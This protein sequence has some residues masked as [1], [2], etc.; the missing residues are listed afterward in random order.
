VAAVLE[1]RRHA[2]YSVR[3]DTTRLSGGADLTWRALIIGLLGVLGLNL[4]TPVNDFALGNTYLTGNH[5]PVG[6]FFLLLILV[7]VVNLLLGWARR[8]WPL[9]RAE[10]MLVFTMMLVASTVPASGL[11]RYWFPLTASP[12]YLSQRSDF[13]WED[14]VLPAAP[15]GILLS[16]DPHSV[17]SR[18][19]FLG[20]PAGEPVVVPWHEWSRVILAWSP[21]ILC[22]YGATFFLCGILRRQWVDRERLLFPIARVPLELTEGVGEGGGLPPVFRSRA[23][24]VG[25]IVVITFGLIRVA[26]VLTGAE[27]GTL[28]TVP[29]RAFLQDTPLSRMNVADGEVYPLIIGIAFLVAAEVSL[30]MWLFFLLNCAENQLFYSLAVPI[31]G[32]PWGFLVWQQAGA[33]LA[34]TAAMLW[35]SRRHLLDVARNALGIGRRTDDSAEPVSFRFAAW[36]LLGCSAGMVAWYVHFGL[37]IG[38]A[39]ALL[40]LVFS[41]VLVHARLICQGGVILTG[42][43]WTP[44]TF[45]HSIMGGRAFSPEAVVVVQAQHAILTAD[46]REMLSPHAMNAMR[47]A[48]VFERHRRLFLPAMFAALLV[49]LPASGYSTLR[50]VY[51]SE[52]ALNLQNQYAVGWHSQY[53]YNTAHEMI[54]NPSGSAQPHYVGL[55][56]GAGVMLLLQGLRGV[57]YWWPVNPLGF[58]L[59]ASW[60]IRPLWFSFLLGWL[61]KVLV[62]KFGAGGLLRSFRMFFLGVIT[63]EVALV[64]IGTFVSL[65]TDIRIGYIFLPS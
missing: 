30:S 64:G 43:A 42:Q 20:T 26:P 56:F 31:R 15:E 49:A 58:L 62:L 52:G 13:F 57:F 55:A 65:L 9:H 4:L 29:V 24:V 11:M 59:S 18:K 47:I 1:R 33:F 27:Q 21:F 7:L 37:T 63:G 38:V 6:A 46:C 3:P 50:W 61:A 28:F 44:P 60:A 8:T 35:L 10:L 53:A 5:F 19:F 23:F 14:Y 45:L 34:F 54:S 2:R 40:A 39:I 12:P 25:L 32:G 16:K 36:A 51:Y 41:L 22:Y 48:S 17:A